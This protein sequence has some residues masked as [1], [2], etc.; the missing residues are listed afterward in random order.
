M[1]WSAKLFGIFLLAFAIYI[2]AS[3]DASKWR[4]IFSNSAANT[5][6]NNAG[7]LAG[8]NNGPA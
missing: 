2:Y 4:S 6:Q 5:N 7:N 8:L 1:T 3:G